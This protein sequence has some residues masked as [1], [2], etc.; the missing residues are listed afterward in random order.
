MLVVLL[1]VFVCFQRVQILVNLLH[2]VVNAADGTVDT[3]HGRAQLAQ[4][5]ALRLAIRFVFEL[6]DALLLT[7]QNLLQVLVAFVGCHEFVVQAFDDFEVVC[8]SCR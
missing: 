7:V 5:F 3:C 8:A 2:A 1:V 6:L 4:V